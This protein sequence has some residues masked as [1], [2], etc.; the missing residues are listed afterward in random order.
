MTG[1]LHAAG[2]RLEYV[3]H[4]PPPDRAPTLVFLHEGLRGLLAVL[5]VIAEFVG[6]LALRAGGPG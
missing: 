5:A 1:F 6:G 4:G 3:W 2:Q